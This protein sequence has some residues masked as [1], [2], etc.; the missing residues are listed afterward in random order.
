R[1]GLARGEAHGHAGDT[2]AERSG[3][4]L[5]ALRPVGGRSWSSRPDSGGG[6]VPHAQAGN[7][8]TRLA[9]RRLDGRSP[10]RGVRA[11]TPRR[12]PANP[13]WRPPDLDY[14]GRTGASVSGL[15]PWTGPVGD[16]EH[17]YK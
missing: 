3:R 16:G 10:R 9:S 7:R 12:A 14:Y 8:P 5:P 13:T 1:R 11:R 2:G 6:V 17:Y 4:H 15:Y